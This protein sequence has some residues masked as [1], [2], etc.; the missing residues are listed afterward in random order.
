MLLIYKDKN[1]YQKTDQSHVLSQS[2]I[3][4]FFSLLWQPCVA[5]LRVEFLIES[6]ALIKKTIQFLSDTRLGHLCMY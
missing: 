1:D 4:L 2:T 5:L 6:C 3:N